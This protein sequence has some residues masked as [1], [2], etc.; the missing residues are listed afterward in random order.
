MGEDNL[1]LSRYFPGE[2][3]TSRTAV[4]RRPHA[5]LGRSCSE[6]SSIQRCQEL[7]PMAHHRRSTDSAVTIGLRLRDKAPAALLTGAGGPV[8]PPKRGTFDDRGG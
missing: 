1:A 4:S 5:Q 8:G 6:M 3:P 7:L 2:G